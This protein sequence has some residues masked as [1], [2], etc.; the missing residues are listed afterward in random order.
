VNRYANLSGDSG[1][2]FY[3]IGVDSITVEFQDGWRYL[4]SHASA[5]RA[6]V[7]HMITLAR[8]GRGLSTFISREVR[9]RYASKWRA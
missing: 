9:E 3:S 1:V 7:E 6:N 4:Y 5:G 2:T 8:A